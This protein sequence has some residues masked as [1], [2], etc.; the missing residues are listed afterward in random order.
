MKPLPWVYYRVPVPVLPVP[1][2]LT[3]CFSRVHPEPLSN[4][5]PLQR[6]VHYR[7]RKNLNPEKHISV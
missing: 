7:N 2:S 1:L 3:P 5:Q 6:F 4:F